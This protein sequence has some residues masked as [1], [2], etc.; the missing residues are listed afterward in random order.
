MVTESPAWNVLSEVKEV[1]AVVSGNT[2]VTGAAAVMVVAKVLF[3][4][5]KTFAY[6]PTIGVVIFRTGHTA[7]AETAEN[8]PSVSATAATAAMRLMLVF[9]DI[10]FLSLVELRTIRISA[11]AESAL[12]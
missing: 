2:N 4:G 11:W 3:E 5:S 9:V 6:V 12:S 10:F 7:F 1:F 8:P